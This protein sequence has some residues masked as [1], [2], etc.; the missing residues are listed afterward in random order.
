MFNRKSVAAAC[1]A[2]ILG[3]VMAASSHAFP[4]ASKTTYLTFS[5]PVALPGVTLPAGT[6]IFELAD[7]SQ[8][9]IVQVRS[10][11]RSRGYWM[12]FTRL[13]RRPA[14]IGADRLATLG[15][16]PTGTPAPITAWY[17]FFYESTG[18]EFI[19]P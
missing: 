9:N 17:P 4:N 15:E 5:G 3:L 2:A 18:Y 13:T 12:G 6:Y 19:Y 8:R 1:G 14:G 10:R 11:D 7:S 16:A